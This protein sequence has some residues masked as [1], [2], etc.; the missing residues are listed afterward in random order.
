[1]YAQKVK[2][3]LRELIL[4]KRDGMDAEQRIDK[5]IA[6][7]ELANQ[8]IEFDPGT[9]I[10]GFFPIKSEIDPR[11]LMDY[12]RVRGAVLCLPVIIDKTK[13]IFRELVRG[14]ELIDT[15]FGTLGPADDVRLVDP[16][17]MLVPLSVFDRKGGRIGYGAGYYD[18]A[19][20]HLAEKG[21]TPVTIGMAFDCQQYDLVPQEP[22][23][24][25]MNA[26]IT[27]SGYRKSDID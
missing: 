25:A 10:S 16:G 18:Q 14:A 22:H 11:P 24:I 21:I 4:K 7:A 15:G 23:D 17:I 13:I 1:M 6:A 9:V 20:S 2:S 26:M 3:E 12:F 19:I 27:E 5:S 8:H